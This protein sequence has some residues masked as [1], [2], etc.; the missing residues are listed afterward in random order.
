MFPM[1][2]F[3]NAGQFVCPN[4]EDVPADKVERYHAVI[5]ARDVYAD[6]CLQTGV[7]RAA[8]DAANKALIDFRASIRV[9][10]R[11]EITREAIETQRRDE[12]GDALYD[13][14]YG[15]KTAEA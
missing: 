5:A 15:P 4:L 8:R 14:V 11:M 7:A 2:L 13:A 6:A 1:Q 9:P 3:D 10:S 12:L